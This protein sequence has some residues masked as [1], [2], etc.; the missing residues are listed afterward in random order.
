MWWRVPE[1]EKLEKMMQHLLAIMAKE[2][3]E[4]EGKLKREDGEWVPQAGE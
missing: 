2:K 3:A 4:G 1:T